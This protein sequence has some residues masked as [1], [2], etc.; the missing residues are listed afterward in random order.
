MIG[1]PLLELSILIIIVN[2]QQFLPH[3]LV[4]LPYPRYQSMYNM[5]KTLRM[6]MCSGYKQQCVGGRAFFSGQFFR[7]QEF[8]VT[9]NIYTSLFTI[10]WQMMVIH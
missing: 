2:N 8:L 5:Q 7:Q 1:N 9:V 3:K 6:H 4:S 10:Y